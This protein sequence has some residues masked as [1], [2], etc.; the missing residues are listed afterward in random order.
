MGISRDITASKYAAAALDAA[1]RESEMFIDSVPSI[2]IGV[3]SL[4]WIVRW[5]LAAAET[6]GLPGG[7]VKGRPLTDCGIAWLDH[8]IEKES[9]LG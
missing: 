7:A 6:F 5:N 8:D 4:G 9:T 3:N 1:H 2:L